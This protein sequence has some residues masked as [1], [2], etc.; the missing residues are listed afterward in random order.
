L[1]R[2]STKEA[3]HDATIDLVVGVPSRSALAQ[4]FASDVKPASPAKGDVK[5]ER[6]RFRNRIRKG[7]DAVLLR[8]EANLICG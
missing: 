4:T 3:C 6:V 8:A 1:R 7:H 2:G 5:R